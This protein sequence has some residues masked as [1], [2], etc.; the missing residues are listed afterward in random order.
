MKNYIDLLERVLQNGN[1]YLDRTQVGCYSIFGEQLKF[2]ISNSFPL[3]TTKKVFIK[4]VIHELLWFLRGSTNSL[5]LEA[6]GVNIWKGNTSREFLDNKGLNHLPIG[7]IGAGYG[8][9]WRHYNA[10]YIDCNTDY[11]N[12]GVDQ[13]KYILEEINNN[14]NSRRIYMTAWNPSALNNMALPPCHLSSQFK[15]HDNKLS[16][17]V[18]IRSNDLFLGLPFNIASYALLVYIIAKVSNLEP[19]ELIIFIG[20]AHIYKNHIDQVKEQLTRVPYDLPTLTIN[21]EMNSVLV[22]DK[23]KWIESLQF[24]DFVIND[25]NYHPAIKADMAI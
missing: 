22:E 6:Q 25:Y 11:T 17:C 18:Y 19:N 20:D 3:L 14:P 21:K 15:V 7:S 16:C 24:E 23:I 5:E 13:L 1:Y 4:G 2:D 10:E 9:Q 8:H 12:K